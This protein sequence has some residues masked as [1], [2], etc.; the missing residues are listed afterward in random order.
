MQNKKGKEMKKSNIGTIAGLASSIAYF[1]LSEST[2]PK[3]SN[4]S[5]LAPASTDVLAN[6]GGLVLLLRSRKTDDPYIAFIGSCILGIH[7]Q[8]WLK[9]K[10]NKKIEY[11]KDK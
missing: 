6:I 7:T 8:Q 4:C 2:V 5:Y 3:D 1:K 11:A 9:H 10:T